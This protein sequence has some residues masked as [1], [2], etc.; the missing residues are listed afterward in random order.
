M[1]HKIEYGDR[2][3]TISCYLPEGSVPDKSAVEELHQMTGL[4]ETL[5][6]LGH[7]PVS[8]REIRTGSRR[9]S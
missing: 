7:I 8:S 1:V 2:E 3:N 9:S 6:K 4:E 5:E